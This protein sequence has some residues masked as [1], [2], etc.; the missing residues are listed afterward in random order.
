[1]KQIS[2]L[3]V[4]GA[5]PQF[6]KAAVVSRAIARHNAAGAAVSI[7][8]QI[9]HT[10]QH[11]DEN[12]S[13]VFFEE[14]EIPAPAANLQI[15][16]GTHGQ[17]TGRML[18]AVEAQILQRKPDWVLVYGDTNST[19][20]GAL[21]AAKLHVPVAHVEAGLRSYNQRMPEEVNRVLTDHVSTLLMC[22][23]ANAVENLAREG[24]AAGVHCVGD[25]MYD[26]VLHYRRKAI[27]PAE[28]GPFA[29]ATIHRA[30]NTDDPDRLRRILAALGQASLPVLLPLHPRTRAVIVREGIRVGGALRI[31]EPLSYFAM[32][33]HL[34]G[35]SFVVTDSGGLQKEAYFFGR[36]CITVRRET[37]WVE[38]VAAGHNRLA[39]A[40]EQAIAAALEWAMQPPPAGDSLYGAGDAAQ[41]LIAVL[42]GAGR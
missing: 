16:S 40:D 39:D 21:A 18:E 30:E 27:A 23:T 9:I 5:R 3:T 31:I 7:T 10:G 36:K 2:L 25:V 35:C 28:K 17:T 8:E 33:G 12:M 38:L 15:G 26:A 37:E 4:V 13:R 32:L 42:A 11:Y 22:P 24:I 1:V 29:L 19:L 14:M 34:Q 41:R 20:A 6:V